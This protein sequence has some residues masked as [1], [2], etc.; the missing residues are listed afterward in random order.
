[1][2]SA[3]RPLPSCPL[4]LALLLGAAACRD[5]EVTPPDSPPTSTV[6]GS[7][8]DST[9]AAPVPNAVAGIRI[10]PRALEVVPGARA[11]VSVHPVNAQGLPSLASLAGPVRWRV[12]NVA[13]ATVSDSGFVHGV[14]VGSTT[15]YASAGELRDSIVVTVTPGTPRPPVGPA[16][17]LRLFPR[18][19]TAAVGRGA[20]V[21]AQLVD[22]NGQLTPTRGRQAE[23]HVQDAAIARL[24]FTSAASDTAIH[25]TLTGVAAGT[26]WLHV[27]VDGMR[28]SLAVTVLPARDSIPRTDT[29]PPAPPP[30][31]VA[32]FTLTTIA[33]GPG[34][35]PAAGTRDTAV[36]V[37][38]P[39]AQ[40]ELFRY[41]RTASTQPADSLGTRVLVGTATTD[42]QGEAR[43]ADLPSAF[44]R[45]R[46]TPPAGSGLTP[47]FTE[48]GPPR[49][50]EYRIGLFLPRQP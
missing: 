11:A 9:P 10:A 32:R 50:A 29:L 14:A 28:D 34:A 2:R 17:A 25:A 46:I 6:S 39:G 21:Q 36:S 5:G 20:W 35:P 27:A 33:L 24:T 45:V 40:V 18:T 13:V 4:A 31:P 19:L 41:E 49:I 44:Y 15:L 38:L 1:M 7:P 26:T 3:F 22:A 16:V 30:A 48:F 12:S 43:F 37:R 8:R 23:W 47:A 42:A